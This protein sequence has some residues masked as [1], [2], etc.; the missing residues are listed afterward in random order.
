M[1]VFIEKMLINFKAVNDVI[2]LWA[3]ESNEIQLM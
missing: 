2:E 3:D 1:N